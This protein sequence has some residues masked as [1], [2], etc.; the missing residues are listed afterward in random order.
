MTRGFGISSLVLLMLSLLMARAQALPLSALTVVYRFSF[1]NSERPT[2]VLVQS[3]DGTLYGV[4]S[5][6]GANGGGAVFTFN[7]SGPPQTLYSF[8]GPSAP[9]TNANGN[10]PVAGLVLGPD[11]NFYGSTAFGGPGENGTVYKITPTGELTTLASFGAAGQG[12]NPSAPLFLAN[13]G[14]L[15]GTTSGG[16]S[17]YG[18]IYRIDPST[19]SLQYVFKFPTDGSVGGGPYAGLVQGTDGALYGTSDGGVGQ[20]TGGG[21]YRLPLG[22]QATNI[23]S[24]PPILDNAMGGLV[25]GPDGAFYGL[26]TL[27]VSS[28]GFAYKVT[29]DGELIQLHA[30]GYDDSQV[31]GGYPT[32]A[33]ILASDGNFYGVT[34]GGGIY[35][36]GVIFQMTPDGTVTT[37]HAFTDSEGDMPTSGLMEGQDGRLYG[38]TQG[39]FTHN[40]TLFKLALIPAPPTNLQAT[41]TT[42]SVTLTW[43]AVKS[44]TTYNVYQGSTSGGESASAT[45][46][47]LAGTSATIAGLQPNST[48]YFRVTA[49][50]EAGEGAASSETIG[51]TTAPARSGGGGSIDEWFVMTLGLA[52][53]GRSRTQ[54]LG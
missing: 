54:R 24:L 2:G 1:A 22:G 13:D 43:Q 18:T 31:D 51:V 4:L 28:G 20:N 11:G 21:I 35:N 23:A 10:I 44:A 36:N 25:E 14:Y 47:Q 3:T 49:T 53:F 41:S 38:M 7:G 37:M 12:Q 5:G 45:L 29:T 26:S 50:N 32:G 34:S 17:S 48:Y 52:F 19:G 33:L 8:G 42:N 15:Y 16:D 46:T 39:V 6:G 9:V 27:G 30:F 40:P